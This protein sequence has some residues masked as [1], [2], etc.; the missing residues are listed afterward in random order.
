MGD[1]G[2]DY[3]AWREHKKKK[4]QKNFFKWIDVMDEIG[5]VELTMGVYRFG[6][7]DLYPYKDMARNY[8]T[9]EWSSIKKVVR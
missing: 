2:D 4:R 7:W 6:S 1:L 3:R 5:A 9:G 8:K